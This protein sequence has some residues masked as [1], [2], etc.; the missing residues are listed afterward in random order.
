MTPNIAT[1]YKIRKTTDTTPTTSTK[2]D[3]PCGESRGRDGN[4]PSVDFAKDAEGSGFL[5]HWSALLYALLHEWLAK[6]GLAA[7]R[8]RAGL[9][10]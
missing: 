4:D 1:D 10:S 6:N 2:E 8:A 7:R 3:D 5:N 9:A